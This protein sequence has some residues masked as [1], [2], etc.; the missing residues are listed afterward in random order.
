MPAFKIISDG[1]KSGTKLLIDGTEVENLTEI[2]FYIYSFSDCPCISYTTESKDSDGFNKREN[3]YFMPDNGLKY[4]GEG[5]KIQA[6]NKG[7][8]I[9]KIN[10]KITNDK[11]K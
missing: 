9:V 7:A 5:K 4:V 8:K 6:S 10:E 2:S 3:Y 1:T 11:T